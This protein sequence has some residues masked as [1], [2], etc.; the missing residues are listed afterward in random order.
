[1]TDTVRE[2][3]LK[4]LET[5]MASMQADFPVDDPYTVTWSIISREDIG[6]LPKTKRYALA[7]Y[8]TEEEKNPRTYPVTDCRL[9]VLLEFHVYLQ[10]GEKASTELN[11]VL[12]EIERKVRSDRTLGDTCIETEFRGNEFSVDGPYEQQVSGVSY[13]SILY[14]HHTDDPRRRV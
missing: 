11:R 8:D 12:G 2:T 5:L 13:L 7:I 1:M 10:K 9:R 14:R 6:Q 3:I 4:A